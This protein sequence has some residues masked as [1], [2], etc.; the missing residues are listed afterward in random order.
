MA[1]A[2]LLGDSS[3]RAVQNCIQIAC[4]SRK[5]AVIDYSHPFSESCYFSSQK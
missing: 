5:P 4:V 1:A 2:R 3:S